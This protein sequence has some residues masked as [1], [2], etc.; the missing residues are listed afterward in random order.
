[1]EFTAY[2]RCDAGIDHGLGHFSRCYK[3]A[4][5]LKKKYR[6]KNI[7]F[8]HYKSK[9]FLDIRGLEDLNIEKKFYIIGKFDNNK[10]TEVEDLYLDA[11]DIR[12]NSVNLKRTSLTGQY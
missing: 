12:S 8:C 1:M 3:I 6:I 7:F 11:M 2:F 4:N 10:S 9:E 5:F